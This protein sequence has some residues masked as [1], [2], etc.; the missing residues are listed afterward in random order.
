MTMETINITRLKSRLWNWGRWARGEGP[1]GFS[2][3][4]GSIE[5]R[6]VAP[7]PDGE[8]VAACGE[9]VDETDATRIERA[10]TNLRFPLDRTFL[11]MAYV[12]T[13]PDRM[14]CRVLKIPASLFEVYHLRAL[15]ALAYRL[16]ELSAVASRTRPT[17]S[18]QKAGV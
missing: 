5:R 1:R 6:F 11:K 8:A 18:L 14:I 17:C 4:Y 7:R 12:E 3:T 15:G 16:D 10:V 9:R 13:Q 2:G